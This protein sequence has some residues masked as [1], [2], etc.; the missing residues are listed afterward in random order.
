MKI[1][2]LA[3]AVFLLLLS[4]Q[5]Y[6]VPIVSIGAGTAVATVDRQ[7]TFDGIQDGDSL[8]NYTEDNLIVSV[9]GN[10]C[11]YSQAH[12]ESGGNNSFVTITTTDGA[13]ILALEAEISSGF[14]LDPHNI[15]WETL[16][17][18]AST[19][20]GI[21]T[22][23][24]G[25]GFTG[26]GQSIVAGWSDVSS[27]DTLLLGAGPASGANAYS[28]FGGTQA[29]ALDNIQVQLASSASVPEPSTITLMAIGFIGIGAARKL[30]KY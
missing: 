13:D 10:H 29:I 22:A 14:G 16:L 15:V 4:V 26:G 27:F 24:F 23:T 30:K 1:M 17:N 2:K 28:G 7:A 18:G 5:V 25:F 6:A 19:G 9:D 11:C 3:L 20:S 12:Y 8:L 21:I